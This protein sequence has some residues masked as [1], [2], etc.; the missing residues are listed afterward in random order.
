MT[1]P[2]VLTIIINPN[3]TTGVASPVFAEPELLR[4]PTEVLLVP[5]FFLESFLELFFP[6]LLPFESSYEVILP[7]CVETL[8]SGVCVPPGII[9]D[10]DSVVASVGVSCGFG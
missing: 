6:V 8:E 3:T 10:V 5:L 2:A 7:D 9:L 4:V 1:N